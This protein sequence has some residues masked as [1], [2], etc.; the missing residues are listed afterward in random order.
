MAS[1]ALCLRA[2]DVK[3]YILDSS[4][5][6][7]QVRREPFHESFKKCC[8]SRLSEIFRYAQQKNPL[9]AA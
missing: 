3:C 1:V 6:K 4:Y 5:Q 9:D 7:T 2:I 8:N